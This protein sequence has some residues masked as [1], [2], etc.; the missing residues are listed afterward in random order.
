MLRTNVSPR[1][2]GPRPFSGICSLGG[3][4]VE[5]IRKVP[6]NR[7]LRRLCLRCSIQWKERS[8]DIPLDA[9]RLSIDLLSEK[10]RYWPLDNIICDDRN[11]R[12]VYANVKPSVR[13]V[14]CPTILILTPWSGLQS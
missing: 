9:K 11:V 5:G 14:V 10:K 4:V 6:D 2:A 8:G 12:F 1:V 13:S 7:V 3:F